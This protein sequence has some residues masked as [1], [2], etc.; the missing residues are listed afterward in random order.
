MWPFKKKKT[1][2]TH[3]V[4]PEIPWRET[5]SPYTVPP[6]MDDQRPK[7]EVESIREGAP[8]FERRYKVDVSGRKMIIKIYCSRYCGITRSGELVQ[9]NGR[10]VLFDPER[11][12]DKILD[13]VLVPLIEQCL[14]EI[15]ALDKTFRSSNPNEFVDSAGQKWRR[16]F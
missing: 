7:I 11:V 2:A 5:K 4:Q 6:G 16:I 10:W 12:A 8:Q 3:G 9:S 15:F 13:P 1:E 14:A